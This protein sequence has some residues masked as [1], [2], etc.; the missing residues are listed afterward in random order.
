MYQVTHNM[1]PNSFCTMYTFNSAI[2]A[3]CTRSK[4][5]I[6]VDQYRTNVHK[7]SIKI[8]GTKLWNSLPITLRQLPSL[9]QFKK[10]YK[11]TLI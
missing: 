5:N 11:T 4:N 3:Y 8:H 6:H 10:A 1:M 2:H 7:Y 9:S